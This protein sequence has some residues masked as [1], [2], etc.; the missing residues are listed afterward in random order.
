[1]G[2]LMAEPGGGR[3][4][5][6]ILGEKTGRAY[7]RLK[8]PERDGGRVLSALREA[9]TETATV[10]AVTI[11]ARTEPD[12]SAPLEPLARELTLTPAPNGKTLVGL[13]RPLVDA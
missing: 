8:I 2:D 10:V 6:D 4:R 11:V 9:A 1:M 3:L 5:E 12:G 13:G 7:L